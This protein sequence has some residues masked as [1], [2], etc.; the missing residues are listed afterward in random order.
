M[1]MTKMLSTALQL[2]QGSARV[3]EGEAGD[4][5][6][7][8][9]SY[10]G[11]IGFIDVCG[12]VPAVFFETRPEVAQRVQYYEVHSP[13]QLVATVRVAVTERLDCLVV[14]DLSALQYVFRMQERSDFASFSS[15][16]QSLLK[17]LAA[18]NNVPCFLIGRQ[19]RGAQKE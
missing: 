1:V 4:L 8:C 18:E 16:V 10:S 5:E 3:A 14:Y 11:T 6:R 15:H 19:K 13:A 9:E 2:I 12:R 17:R 7:L